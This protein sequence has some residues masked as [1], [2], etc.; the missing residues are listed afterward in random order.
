MS[1]AKHSPTPW[2]IELSKLD[3]DI[4][5]WYLISCA[6]VVGGNSTIF[7]CYNPYDASLMVSAPKL[8]KALESLLNE[9]EKVDNPEGQALR[10]SSFN[11]AVIKEAFD[12]IQQAKGE[13]Q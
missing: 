2:R 4:R 11:P 13:K 7:Q 8:L 5:Y 3:G 9:C 12:A 6:G 10:F 1:E